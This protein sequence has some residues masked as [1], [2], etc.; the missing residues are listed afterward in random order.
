MVGSY[1][2][3]VIIIITI[4]LFN[5]AHNTKANCM[6]QFNQF[7]KKKKHC[8][9]FMILIIYELVKRY[10]YVFTKLIRF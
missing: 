7:K 5:V 10:M 3:Y 4:K 6:S 8:T 1:A 9:G 2:G